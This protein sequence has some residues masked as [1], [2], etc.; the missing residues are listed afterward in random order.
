MRPAALILAFTLLAANLP[1]QQGDSAADHAAFVALDK[2]MEASPPDQRLAYN[3]LVVAFITFRDAH[4]RHETCRDL[5]DCAQLRATERTQSNHDFIRMAHGFSP[6][7][8]PVFTADDLAAEDGTLNDFFDILSGRLGSCP[9]P[10]CLSKSAFQEIER[11]W[12]RYRDAFVTFGS[13]RFP[14][15][16][17]ETWRTYLTRQRID[18]ILKRFPILKST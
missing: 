11:D 16:K 8:P 2:T 3:A 5:A 17:S 10:D 7:P 15:I 9:E 1:A 6:D 13:L 18:Q 14:A 12:I 4:L